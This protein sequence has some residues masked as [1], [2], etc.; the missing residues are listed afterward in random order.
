MDDDTAQ[1]STIPQKLGVYRTKQLGYFL[2]MIFCLLEF[3]KER[4]SLTYILSL[5]FLG[6]M[7]VF[8]LKRSSV[9]QGTYFASF[10]VEAAPMFWLGV[11]YLINGLI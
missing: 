9:E 3:L 6:I 7:C 10:W 11:I 4:M 2:T 8:F 5:I 1:L